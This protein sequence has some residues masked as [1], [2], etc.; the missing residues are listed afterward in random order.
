MKASKLISLFFII[1]TMAGGYYLGSKQD[2][3]D[4][5][6]SA[7]IAPQEE[8]IV[9]EERRERKPA[10][11]EKKTEA[12]PVQEQPRPQQQVA[13]LESK[14]LKENKYINDLLKQDESAAYIFDRT[15]K[16][17]QGKQKA[18][19]I[20]AYVALGT[21]FDSSSEFGEI[22]H[23][24][25]EELNTDPA[26]TVKTFTQTLQEIQPEDS[27]VRAQVLNA[28]NALKLETEV[29]NEFFANE[30][31]REVILNEENE[32]SP[33]SLNITTSLIFLSHGQPSPEQVL[34]AYEKSMS[35]NQD[36]NI[37]AQLRVRFE[38]YF[39]NISFE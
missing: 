7:V 34:T 36:E 11:V 26:Q 2:L 39:P 19:E 21:Q 22:Y 32:F 14:L 27:F 30:A 18:E 4:N 29:R 28:A 9:E 25:L 16:I 15:R 17:F 5:E 20:A 37:Q 3:P 24:V 31:T 8:T 1:L 13:L 35:K 12:Q 38:A 10:M 23:S 6:N 33:D